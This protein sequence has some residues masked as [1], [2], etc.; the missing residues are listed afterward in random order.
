LN[1]TRCGSTRHTLSKCKKGIDE[2][3]PLPFAS[4]FVC[5]DKGHL[6]SACPQ[7]ADKGI[8]PNGGCCKLC[9]EK[10]HLAKDCDLLKKGLLLLAFSATG[11]SLII[12]L[13]SDNIDIIAVMSSGDQQGAD[14]DDFHTFKRRRQEVETDTK[15]EDAKKKMLGLRAGAQS[16]IVKAFGTAPKP[17]KKVVYF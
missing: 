6:A 16:H 15:S 10:S 11:D 4:C 8:Y 12:A 17:A 13:P 3:N 2:S 5:N 9:G 7:N 1:V 14:E